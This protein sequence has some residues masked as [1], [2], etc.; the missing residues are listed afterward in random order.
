MDAINAKVP[1]SSSATARYLAAPVEKYTLGDATIALRVF[2]SGPAVMLVHGYPVHGYTWRELLPV[3]EQHFTCYVVDLPGLGDSEWDAATDFSFT[4][5]AKR[6]AQLCDSLTPSPN[7]LV[8][9]DTGAT[10]ARMVAAA[11]PATIVGLVMLNTEIPGHRP[12]WIRFYQACARIPLVQ[13]AF[14]VLLRSRGF[15]RS[16]MGLGQFYANSTLLDADHVDPYIQPLVTS[17][18][19]MQGMLAYLRGIDWGAVDGLREQH[20]IIRARILLLWGE[21]DKTFPVEQAE[22]MTEQ[23][24][25]SVEFIRIPTAAL[26]PHEEQPEEILKHVFPF[27]SQCSR[28]AADRAK[29]P[30]AHVPRHVSQ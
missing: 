25:G 14:G 20:A 1:L 28:A 5:Q 22:A 17:R 30:Q 8:A 18:R 29:N 13:Y 4:A 12:P 15:V 26:M 16:N 11:R 21:Q 10:I 27:I 6:L 3:L 7:C 9:H 19:R 24:Q 23:M 2:G